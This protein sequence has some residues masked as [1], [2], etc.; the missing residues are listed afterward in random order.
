MALA[1]EAGL[2]FIAGVARHTLLTSAA[3]TAA[4]PVAALATFAPLLDHWH[5]FGSWTQL[6]M[7]IRVLTETLSRPTG[8][9]TSPC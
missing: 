8:T 3:R 9:A 1:E 2:S 4:D 5:G 6:W 7:A